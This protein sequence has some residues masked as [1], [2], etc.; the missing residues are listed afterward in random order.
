MGIVSGL[1]QYSSN[2]CYCFLLEHTPGSKLC[3]LKKVPCDTCI[4]CFRLIPHGPSDAYALFLRRT[5]VGSWGIFGSRGSR[6]IWSSGRRVWGG[7]T[8]VCAGRTVKKALYILHTLTF[9]SHLR[10]LHLLTHYFLLRTSGQL[11]DFR[12]RAARAHL[13]FRPPRLMRLAPRNSR[14]R[15]AQFEGF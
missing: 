7:H 2:L 11:R 1:S 3:Y 14:V 12:A 6:P 9:L 5:G 10:A 13:V 15:T 8:T 4:P